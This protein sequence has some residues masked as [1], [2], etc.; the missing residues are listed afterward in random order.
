LDIGVGGMFVPKDKLSLSVETLEM[1]LFIKRNY[2]FMDWNK[3]VNIPTDDIA[4]YMP[5]APTIPFVEQ[6]QQDFDE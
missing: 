1:K 2:H 4:K 3:M 5:E 6:N